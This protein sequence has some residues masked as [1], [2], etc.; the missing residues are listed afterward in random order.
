MTQR[1]NVDNQREVFWQWESLFNA[2]EI[3]NLNKAVK[4][5]LNSDGID[6]PANVT[7]TSKVE[8]CLYKDLKPYLY[9]IL[10]RVKL[11]NKEHFGYSIYDINDYDLIHIN[12]YSSKNKG[13]YD[14]HIDANRT[15]TN[16]IKFTVLIN[17]SEKKYDGGNFF[18]FQMGPMEIISLSKP[19]TVVM[20]QS[21]IPHKVLPV[22]AGSRKTIAI[23]VKGPRFV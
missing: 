7:K 20:F 19:G 5:N 14:W 16:D 8:F 17:I 6:N 1:K 4:N 11:T 15:W 21:W 12:T 9:D 10:E 22:I 2:S 23:F 3:K 13:R 18:L